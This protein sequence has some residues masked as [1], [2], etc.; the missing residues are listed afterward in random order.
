M[1]PES[2]LQVMPSY[3]LLAEQKIELKPKEFTAMQVTDPVC[4]M[5]IDSTEAAATETFQGRRYYFCSASC[6]DKFRA[7]PERYIGNEGAAGDSRGSR[8]C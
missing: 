6:R 1:E 2:A 8:C 3:I 5:Q 4:G 7:S